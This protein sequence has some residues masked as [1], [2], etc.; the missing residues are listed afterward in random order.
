MKFKLKNYFTIRSFIYVCI[1]LKSKYFFRDIKNISI[2]TSLSRLSGNLKQI[3][4]P[5][6]TPFQTYWTHFFNY[7]VWLKC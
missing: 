7:H 1:F 2:N 6:Y 5:Y 4:F 3:S